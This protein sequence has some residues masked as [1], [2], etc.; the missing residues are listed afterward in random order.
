MKVIECKLCGGVH[1]AKR[2][3]MCENCREL[4]KLWTQLVNRC[5]HQHKYRCKGISVEMT[6]ADFMKWGSTE[7]IIFRW[8]HPNE[9]ATVDR[10]DSSGNYRISNIQ[11]VTK[12]V[13]S[14]RRCVNRFKTAM[15]IKELIR[16]ATVFRLGDKPNYSAIARALNCS[17]QTVSRAINRQ[18][19][20]W[21][22]EQID[23]EAEEADACARRA[24]KFARR[25]P[26]Q[27]ICSDPP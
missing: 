5:R 16:L 7:L 19:H 11:L 13:N 23:K 9:P 27:R 26:K 8:H 2:A 6:K 4:S 22:W 20:A 17:T 14:G 25:K 10:I 21:I 24:Y 1:Y 12:S 3:C 15:D 18:T